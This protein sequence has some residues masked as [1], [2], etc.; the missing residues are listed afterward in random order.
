MDVITWLTIVMTIRHIFTLS[1]W[2]CIGTFCEQQNTDDNTEK[3]TCQEGASCQKVIYR[4]EEYNSSTIYS[5]VVKSCSVGTC[6]PTNDS[7][8]SYCEKKD[9]LYKVYGCSFRTCCDDKDFCNS[10]HL[11]TSF[12]TIFWTLLSCFLV[13]RLAPYT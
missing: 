12:Q 7:D 9:R 11:N 1:C 2:N 10:G 4:M 13:Q 6:I 3:K 5:S 8:N